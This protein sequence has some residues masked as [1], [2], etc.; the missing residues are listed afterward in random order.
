V[1]ITGSAG[2]DVINGSTTVAGQPLPT[3]SADLISG[4]LGNDTIDSLLGADTVNGNDGNDAITYHNGAA[5]LHGAAGRDRLILSS[6]DMINLGNTADQSAGPVVV[7]GFEDVDGRGATVALTVTGDANANT[8]WGGLQA[9]W[10]S[11]A[12]G[13]DVLDGKAGADQMA[14]GAGND[15]YYVD[16]TTDVVREAVSPGVDAGGVDLVNSTVSLTLGAFVEKLTLLGTAAVNGTGNALANTLTGNAAA[17]SLSGSGGNDVLDGKAGN[18]VLTGGSGADRFWFDT[19][20]SASANVDQVTDFSVL[21]DTIVLENAVF[22]ALTATGTLAAGAFRVGTGAGDADDRVLYDSAN[23]SLYYDYDGTGASAQV[24]FA[25]LA[26][27][28]GLTNNDF[29]VV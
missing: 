25:T 22:T 19:A 4:G 16:S 17:N 1:T 15:T 14:G 27:G 26:A 12:G 7:T 29:S 24:K 6:T 28:V 13:N 2:N 10:L 18:D 21:D 20:L 5:F 8:L 23:G 11:G 3:N 9:D